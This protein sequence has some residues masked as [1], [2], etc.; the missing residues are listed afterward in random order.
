MC[1][2]HNGLGTASMQLRNDFPGRLTRTKELNIRTRPRSR[3]SFLQG[4]S[5]KTDL[6]AVKLAN[7][8]GLR[9]AERPSGLLVYNV[10]RQP[11]EFRFL[12]PLQEFGGTEVKLMISKN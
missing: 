2:G 11:L 12:H 1:Q 5:K 8:K 7:H 3:F 4:Q 9:A 10:S 6:H